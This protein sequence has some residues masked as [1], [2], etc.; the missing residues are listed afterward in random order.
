MRKHTGK[1][2]KAPEPDG[3]HRGNLRVQAGA[4]DELSNPGNTGTVKFRCREQEAYIYRWGYSDSNLPDLSV[5]NPVITGVMGTFTG[6]VGFFTG[7]PRFHHRPGAV[8]RRH[9]EADADQG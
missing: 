2:W 9:D 6:V 5:P 1:R 4:R 7:I 3:A 8:H